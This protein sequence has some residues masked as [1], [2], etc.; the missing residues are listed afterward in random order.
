M[1]DESIPEYQEI[2]WVVRRICLHRLVILSGMQVEHLCQWL[3]DS[4]RDDRPDAINCQK[5][6]AIVQAAFQYGFLVEKSTWQIVV[7]I[8]KG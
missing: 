2:T 3:I 1:L 7:L 4:T 5:V 6:V 8:P